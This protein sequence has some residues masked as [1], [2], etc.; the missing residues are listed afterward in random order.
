MMVAPS[1]LVRA[2]GLVFLL[3]G[4]LWAALGLWLPSMLLVGVGGMIAVAGTV[5]LGL[6]PRIAER[7]PPHATEHS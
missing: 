7:D 2:G 5:L 3:L 1:M 4:A 6:A